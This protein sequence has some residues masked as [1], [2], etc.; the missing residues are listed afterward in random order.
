MSDQKKYFICDQGIVWPVNADGSSPFAGKLVLEG[1]K[2]LHVDFD[3][4]GDEVVSEYQLHESLTDLGIAIEHSDSAN[5][6]QDSVSL[7]Q[8]LSEA[9]RC[10]QS[11]GAA[12][13]A[14]HAKQP[15]VFPMTLPTDNAGLWGEQMADHTAGESFVD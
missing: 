10:I 8:A 5:S 9:Y 1:Y 15:E 7:E 14:A 13:Q 4:E 3:G 2:V 11:F 6:E 12:W